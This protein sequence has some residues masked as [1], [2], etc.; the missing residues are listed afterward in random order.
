MA[1]IYSL[2]PFLSLRRVTFHRSCRTIAAQ[3]SRRC[4][5]LLQTHATAL[6]KQATA[7]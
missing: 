7:N 3:W 1:S 4:S 6:S 2:L 5:S